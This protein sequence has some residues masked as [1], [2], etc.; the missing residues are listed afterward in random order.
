LAVPT[1]K[2]HLN[3]LFAKFVREHGKVYATRGELIHRQ[4]IFAENL[5]KI[6]E[7]NRSGASY[8][9]G[10]SG[11]I[12]EVLSSGKYFRLDQLENSVVD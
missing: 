7:H 3:M 5:K 12:T 4:K 11:K 1:D 9:M 2:D 10:K 6:E 8:T